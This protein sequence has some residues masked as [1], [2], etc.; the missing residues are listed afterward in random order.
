MKYIGSIV[1]SILCC[2]DSIV[3]SAQKTLQLI[4]EHI[5]PVISADHP[6]VVASANR[7]GFETGQVIKLNGVYHM[8]VNEMFGTPHRDLRIAYWTSVDAVNWKRQSTIVS[9][10]PGR[11]AFNPK[12]EV[13]VNAV[14]FNEEE[15]AWNI[16][17]VAYRA[18]DS[19]KGEIAGNDYAGRIW[20]AKSIVPGRNGIAGSY[21]DM[22]IMLQPDANSQ[23][24][25]G[26]Q[27]VASFFPYKVGNTWY[28]MYD[29]HY[30]TPKGGW[31]TGMAFAK[32]VNGPWTRMPEPFN[33][34]QVAGVF[35]ENE[36]VSRLK[37]GRY[38]MIFDS[39]GD[40]QIGYSLSDDGIHWGKETRITVQSSGKIWA[41]PGDHYTR[42]PLCAI[43]EEE[44]T[45]TV[46]YTAMMKVNG[47]NFYAVGKCS[48]AWK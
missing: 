26:Q 20:R 39:F 29:G 19:T 16:F 48:L 44:G 23:L 12:A 43:E 30:H 17:Y 9:S 21:A 11:T 8:F 31:P 22:N 40:Q 38:L 27:A 32:N 36:V 10:I 46:V 45:Y 47:K 25:E 3:S 18:G 4:S 5:G 6:D 37:D 2:F 24:W 35:M 41:Q 33:P 34:I 13:W 42:T 1:L 28:A 14:L 7:S 15:N